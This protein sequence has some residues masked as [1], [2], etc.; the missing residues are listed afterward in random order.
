M[1]VRCL[2]AKRSQRASERWPSRLAHRPRH[3]THSS[4]PHARLLLCDINEGDARLPAAAPGRTAPPP[5]L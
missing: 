2:R 1:P 5:R 3:R 4:G